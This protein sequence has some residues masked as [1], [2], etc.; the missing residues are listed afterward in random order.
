MA[1]AA[2]TETVPAQAW[3]LYL[4]AIIWAVAYDTLYAMADRTDDLKIGVKSTAI[5]FGHRDLL[6]VGISQALVMGILALIGWHAGRGAVYFAGLLS[7]IGFVGYQLWIV[8]RR[9]PDRCV[10]AFLNNHWLGLSIFAA[11][12]ID[13]AIK[14]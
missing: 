9:E 4:A 13:Y 5:L 1:Y 10:Q 12:L 11:L 8:R 14:P 7:S 6:I 2:Q 3:W